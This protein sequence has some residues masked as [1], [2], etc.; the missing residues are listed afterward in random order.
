[1]C[2][3]SITDICNSIMCY[4]SIT[5]IYNSIM[6]YLSITDICNSIMCYLSITDIYNSIMCYLSITDIYNS[7]MCYLSITAYLRLSY[8][9]F[10]ILGFKTWSVY[11]QL[12]LFKHFSLASH[13]G[14][15]ANNIYPDQMPQN[16]A[17]DQRLHCLH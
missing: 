7:I 13:K 9:G 6:C 4:L 8:H 11:K 1:M 5:D 17:S 15:S 2:Y 12:V 3:L 10:P 16:V 14:T